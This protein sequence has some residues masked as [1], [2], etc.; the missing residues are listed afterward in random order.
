MKHE[1]PIFV[2]LNVQSHQQLFRLLIKLVMYMIPVTNPILTKAN[3]L[4]RQ[5]YG[6]KP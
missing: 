5:H 4:K 6:H 1:E 3:L 2:D